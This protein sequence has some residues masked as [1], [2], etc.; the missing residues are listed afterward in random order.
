MRCP[1]SI[2]LSELENKPIYKNTDLKPVFF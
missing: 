2:K 1:L